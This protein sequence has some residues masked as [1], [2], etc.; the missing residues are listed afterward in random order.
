MVNWD[1]NTANVHDQTFQPLPAQYDGAMIVLPDSGF[2]QAK[3]LPQAG[4]GSDP[5]NVKLR[6]RGQW[7]VRMTVEITLAGVEVILTPNAL[8]RPVRVVAE[9]TGA[10]FCNPLQFRRRSCLP[11]LTQLPDYGVDQPGW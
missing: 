10:V 11:E 3:S 1:C 4:T 7:N 6:Q 8:Q 9:S 2:H 5:T